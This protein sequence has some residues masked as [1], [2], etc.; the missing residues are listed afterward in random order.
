MKPGIE[1]FQ[2]NVIGLWKVLNVLPISFWRFSEWMKLYHTSQSSFFSRIQLSLRVSKTSPVDTFLQNS[3]FPFDSFESHY[4]SALEYLKIPFRSLL[5]ILQNKK[6]WNMIRFWPFV[7]QTIILRNSK[8]RKLYFVS[9]CNLIKKGHDPTDGVIL[10]SFFWWVLNHF[11]R[12]SF[13]IV[14]FQVYHNLPWEK[15]ARIMPRKSIL[16]TM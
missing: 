12:K 2:S 14:F 10:H 11:L 16:F 7:L 5:F 3:E 13:R 8:L 6:F 15:K 1:I 9:V 4:K